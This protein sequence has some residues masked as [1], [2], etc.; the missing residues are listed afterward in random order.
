MA[1]GPVFAF[2]WLTRSRRWQGYAL[3]ALFVVALLL[4]LAMV[5]QVTA[6]MVNLSTTQQL[7]E[8]GKLF[9]GTLTT[10]QLTLV[11]LAAPAA[12]AGAICVDKSRGS[13]AHVMVTDLSDREIVLGKLGARLIPVLNLAACALPVAALGTL[14]GGIDPVALTG[15]FLI[16]SGVAALGCSLALALSVWVAKTHEVMTIVF[17]AWA[18]WLLPLPFVEIAT[19]GWA[20][21]W[22]Q[23]GHPFWLTMA[24]YENPGQTSLLEPGL[25]LLAC[26]LLSAGLTALAVRMVRPVYLGQMD[27]APR[28]ARESR[29]AGRLRSQ[30]RWWRG[31]SLDADPVFW[32]EW[33]RG[34]PSRWTRAIWTTYAVASTA[35]S[36]CAIWDARTNPTPGRNDLVST[37]VA[38]EGTF[39]LLLVSASAATVL[40]E[41]RARGSLDV[42]LTTPIPTRSIL[43]GK[44]WG[45][46]RRTPWLAVWP[47]LVTFALIPDRAANYQVALAYL[48]PVVI[49]AQGAALASLG[50]ALATWISRLGRAVTWTVSAF[51][52]S[53]IGWPVAAM[54]LLS[55]AD[56]PTPGSKRELVG[57]VLLFGSPLCNIALPANVMDVNNRMPPSEIRGFMAGAITWTIAYSL[58]AAG[59]YLATLLTFDRC[60]GRSPE[61]PRKPRPHPPGKPA[62]PAAPAPSR[63]NAHDLGGEIARPA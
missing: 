3:R 57:L 41:E 59:L 2:E 4:G 42:L 30:V 48:V 45:A 22:L 6:S 58:I 20:P 33:H 24:P 62:R 38:V 1:M 52:G 12:T 40:A 26:L 43:R 15:S 63:Q 21:R 31:P 53:L 55:V 46:F 9:F 18:A 49:I 36:L 51:V 61:R 47:G 5:W 23:R 27:R 29:V 19:R 10:L 35:F 32:R 54:L 37:L 13:L 44:W 60:L 28:A 14:L 34:R 50:L 25:F 39:G 56:G 7:A 16:V 8:A 17:A 11:L